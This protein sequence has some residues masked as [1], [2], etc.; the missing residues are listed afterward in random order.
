MLKKI[1]NMNSDIYIEIFKYLPLSD[2]L[3]CNSLNKEISDIFNK[4]YIWTVRCNIL[5]N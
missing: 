4:D 2:M 1:K 3:N 5:Q